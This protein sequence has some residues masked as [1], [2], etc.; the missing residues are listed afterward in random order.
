MLQSLGVPLKGPTVL[1]GDNL[2]SL[3]SVSN[4]ASPCK[5]KASQV[6]YHYVC[7]C[8]AAGIVKICKIGMDF[9]HADPG[10]KALD[11]GRFW[12]HFDLIF[13]KPLHRCKLKNHRMKK[14]FKGRSYSGLDQGEVRLH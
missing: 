6:A 2:G 13:H 12:A 4:P 1:L 3:M 14:K 5:K 7:E 9:I 11:K 8:I 10:T